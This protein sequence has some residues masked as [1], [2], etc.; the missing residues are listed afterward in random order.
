MSEKIFA[1][2]GNPILHSKSPEMFNFAFKKLGINAI[3]IRIAAFSAKETISIANEIGACGLN[4]TSPFKEEM[5]SVLINI[6]ENAK[7][8]G[9]INCITNEN[10]VWIGHNTDA[11]GVVG[12][13]EHNLGSIAG[14]KI[15]VLG[16]GGAAKAA[17]YALVSKKADVTIINRTFGKAKELAHKFGCKVAKFVELAQNLK[18]INILISCIP[19]CE[20]IIPKFALC[21]K[22]AVLDANYSIQT[23]LI[24]DAKTNDC[25]IIDAR[26]WLFFQAIP[27]FEYFLGR[28]IPSTI[29][30][31]MRETLYTKKTEKKNIALIGFMGSGKTT[32]AKELTN[33]TKMKLIDIDENIEKNTGMKIAQIFEDMGEGEFRKIESAELKKTMKIQ[34]AIISCG[35]GIVLNEDNRNMLRKNC[36]VFWLWVDVKT[37]M[38]RIGKCNSRPLFGNKNRTKNAKKILK[39]RLSIYAK[40][41]DVLINTVGKKPEEIAIRIFYEINKTG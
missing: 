5:I 17:I 8:I 31:T 9:A 39:Q 24:K 4:I 38:K 19:T 18:H 10:N 2:A 1:V 7:T 14:K 3:Y 22:L 36:T 11:N 34:N 16:A 13:L 26:E 41:S 23:A 35:G 28:K 37:I 20:R 27:S 15:I 40:A 12:A 33:L 25:K 21:K 32:I 29:I 30:T 6:D